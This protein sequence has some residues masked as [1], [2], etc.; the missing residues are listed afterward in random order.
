MRTLQRM[1][2]LWLKILLVIGPLVL[3]LLLFE[4]GL[5]RVENSYTFKKRLLRDQAPSIQVL[6]LGS[7]HA[8]YGINPEYFSLKGFNLANVSQP[9]RYDYELLKRYAPLCPDLKLVIMAI[10]DFSLGYNLADSGEYW[11]EFFYARTY[12]IPV[13]RLSMMFDARNY[14]LFALYGR[15]ESFSYLKMRFKVSLTSNI[16]ESGSFAATPPDPAQAG[17]IFS[18]ESARKEVVIHGSVYFERNVPANRRFLE[19]AIRLCRDRGLTPVLLTTPV[20][21]NYQHFLDPSVWLE[22]QG[23]VNDLCTQYGIAYHNFMSD[24]RF[25]AAD[26]VDPDHL[27]STGA[28]KLSG[29]INDEILA[30]LVS[31]RTESR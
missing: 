15:K 23:V 17:Q 25:E 27:N 31:A 4:I 7:S 13:E 1:R 5:S 22:V 18:D 6:V 11:R 26:F 10:S 16:T 9:L 8:Y 19:N 28:R 24:P 2:K 12:R 3:C 29:I 30:H 20:F 21:Q 14:L